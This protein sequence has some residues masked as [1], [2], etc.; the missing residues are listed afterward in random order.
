MRR[1]YVGARGKLAV[2]ARVDARTVEREAVWGVWT[3]LSVE[4]SDGAYCLV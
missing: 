3:V 4:T 1:I 2:D